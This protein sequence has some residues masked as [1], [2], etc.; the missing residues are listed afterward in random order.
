M[1]IKLDGGFSVS[2]LSL[3]FVAS[4]W[5][6]PLVWGQ[7]SKP[8]EESSYLSADINNLVLQQ[9]RNEDKNKIDD[10]CTGDKLLSWNGQPLID[11]DDLI[12]P[13]EAG[14][15]FVRTGSLTGVMQVLGDRTRERLLDQ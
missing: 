14:D 7:E 15:A 9:W 12:N 11:N 4:A 6:V 1:A 13:L 3:V 2:G 8:Q 5:F 10:M